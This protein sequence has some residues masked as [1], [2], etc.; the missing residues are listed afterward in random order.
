MSGHAFRTMAKKKAD[1]VDF[2]ASPA[3]ETDR[4]IMPQAPGVEKSLLSMMTIDPTNVISQCIAD[5]L[6]S[7]YFY[8]PAHRILWEI[9]RERYEKGIAID[10]VS[11]AQELSD[12]KK[13]EAVGGNAGL[14]DIFSFATT[15]ALYS[16]HFETL[17]EKYIRRSIILTANRATD[18]AYTSEAEVEELLDQTEQEVLQIRHASAKGEEWSLKD[19]IEKAVSNLER[20]MSTQGGILGISTGYP[21]LDTMINGM[22]SGELFVIAA[23]PSMGKTSFMLNIVEHVV[24][25]LKL[26]MMAFSCEMPSEQLVERLLYARAAISKSALK[27]AGGKLTPDE[28]KR[29]KSAIT[30]LKNS[31]L[32][33]DDTAGI[34][35]SE[36]RAKAR[37][38]MR[39]Y[40]DLAAIGI[41]YLQLMRSHTKQAQNSR[42]REIAE[43][44]GGLK[45]LAKELKIPIVVL[46]QLNRGPENRTGKNKGTPM[47]SDLR[48]SG[49]IEQDADMIGLLWRS[50]YYAEDD[51]DREK[52]GN[53]ANLLL[54]KN[55]NGPTGDVPL[56]F[57]AEIMRF[58]PRIPT[59]GDEEE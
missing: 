21:K 20:M 1:N 11:V 22:K 4:T 12:T 37:R 48:E 27:A 24:L 57:H 33:I 53:D 25:D 29:F 15:T 54:A 26:P 47:M 38:Q 16:L 51:E 10:T 58:V 28:V 56:S 39:K 13:L 18:A 3:A 44:S 35:I 45:A 19:D 14:M 23:R 32:I 36:L 46:A 17:K 49:A 42:E 59:E 41:D 50:K 55:R 40:P 7:D 6:T 9:F 43:I 31:K 34:S 2:K 8:I 52:A 5:G 30:E